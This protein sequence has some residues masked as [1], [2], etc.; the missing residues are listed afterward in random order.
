MSKAKMVLMTALATMAF[1][2]SAFAAVPSGYDSWVNVEKPTAQEVR[3]GGYCKTIVKSFAGDI[4]AY[5]VNVPKVTREEARN[6]GYC[7]T[8]VKSFG[9]DIISMPNQDG[10]SISEEQLEEMFRGN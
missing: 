1:A 7:K 3:E 8:I 2:A 6:G 5:P 9:G 4:I 10:P